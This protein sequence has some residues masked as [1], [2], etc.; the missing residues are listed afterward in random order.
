MGSGDTG[1][2]VAGRVAGGRGLRK[3]RP[4]PPSRMPAVMIDRTT[5]EPVRRR[6]T[7]GGIQWPRRSTCKATPLS[8][9]ARKKGPHGG[10][11]MPCGLA[12]EETRIVGRGAT[13][14][15]GVPRRLRDHSHRPRLSH[16]GVKFAPG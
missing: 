6:G 14:H 12:E 13:A 7:M 5:Q 3:S 8:C 2:V 1:C 16:A 4:I 11:W 15:E 10:G 9:D